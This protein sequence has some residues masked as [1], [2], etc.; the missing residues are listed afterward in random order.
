MMK[1]LILMIQLMSRIPIPVQV[2]FDQEDLGKGNVY[3]PLIGGVMG[4]LLAGVYWVGSYLY[5]PTGLLVPILIVAAYLWISG[6]LHMDGISDTFDGLWSN[7]SQ[8]R[9]LEIMKD[10]RLGVFGALSLILTILLQVGTLH[11]L[12]G[13]PETYQWLILIPVLGRYGAVFGNFISSYARNDGMGKHFIEKCGI[14]EWLITSLYVILGVFWLVGIWGI[15]AVGIV[16]VFT[17]FFTRWVHSKIGGITG[18]V[19]GAVIELNQLVVLLYVVALV[20]KIYT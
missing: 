19:I 7:R 20:E 3:F 13:L 16:L 12:Q 4:L 10:S 5:Q 15:I 9:M 17:Y 8:E 1:L 6:G 2:H 11:R 14:R 18:D